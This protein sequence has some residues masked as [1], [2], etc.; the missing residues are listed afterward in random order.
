MRRILLIIISVFCFIAL[1]A[2]NN[3]DAE[4][5]DYISGI[6]GMHGTLNESHDF[7]FGF[8][9][10]LLTNEELA[11]LNDFVAIN[12]AAARGGFI[13]EGLNL[14]ITFSDDIT[15]FSL[16]EVYFVDND[17]F[18]FAPTAVLG[19]IPSIQKDTPIL[20]TH[21][22]SSGTIPTSGFSFVS[23]N[24][25]EMFYTFEQSR[26][27]GSIE[28]VFFNWPNKNSLFSMTDVEAKE[29]WV[30]PDPYPH[31]GYASDLEI[32][33]IQMQPHAI[34]ERFVDFDNTI[35]SYF[36]RFNIDYIHLFDYSELRTVRDG[37]RGL[38]EDDELIGDFLMITTNKP[39]RNFAVVL[40]A[41]EIIDDETIFIPIAD[42]GIIDELT[43][44]SAY[45]ISSYISIGAL[46][47]SGVTFI[48]ETG[49]RHF[50][51]IVQNQSDEG[52][53]YMLIRFENRV[54]E[55]P[56]DF[57]PWWCDLI[58]YC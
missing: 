50:Y 18:S 11:E 30:E 13:T 49:I 33:I 39:L 40:L 51:T 26:F 37:R 19:N 15:D 29:D 4:T 7:G 3:T 14:L 25:E 24:G 17:L 47:W 6:E 10:E 16:L 54:H 34:G 43:P 32:S 23:P 42:F 44:E 21:Y 38:I 53:P 46:P 56:E 12:Y 2:C 45:V 31:I 5:I 9:I 58:W 41:N 52:P 36:A 55:L 48:D 20:I 27:D 57:H 28:W 8:V 1:T 22:Y 35:H